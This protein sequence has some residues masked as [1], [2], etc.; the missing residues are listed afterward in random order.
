MRGRCCIPMS[1]KQLVHITFSGF[2]SWSESGIKTGIR[3]TVSDRFGSCPGLPRPEQSDLFSSAA[4][5]FAVRT[6]IATQLFIVVCFLRNSLLLAADFETDVKPVLLRRCTH[7]HGPDDVNGNVRL[8]TLSTDL[9]KDASA[10]ETWHDVLNVL[11][12]GEMPPEDAEPLT[13]S[14]R[15]A[16]TDWITA[17]LKRAVEVRRS[18]GGQV[19]IRR[20]N[21]TEYRNTMRDLLGLDLRY[22]PELLPDSPAE[23]GFTNNGSSL[24]MSSLQL[25]SYLSVAR[26]AMNRAIVTSAR[27]TVVDVTETSSA[28]DKVKDNWTSMLGR[29]GKFVLR[30]TEFPD[31]GEF[32]IQV[33]AR[34]ILPADA[35]Y[36]QL[37]VVLGYRADTQ[38]PSEEVGTVELKNTEFQ[39]YEFRGRLESF[40]L[41]SRTQSK[42]PGLLIWLTNAFSDGRPAPKPRQE[43][44]EIPGKEG[45]KPG[46]QKR[47]V[48]DVDPDFPKIEV[49]S[50]SFKAPVFE[51]W[52][53]SHHTR[54][55][56]P[57][58]LA[59]RDP[60]EYARVVLSRFMRRAFRR[61]VTDDEV[62][63]ML[64]YFHEV[65]PTFSTFEEA[66]RET[67]AM[68]LVAP[69]FLYLV[70]PSSGKSRG[71]T[72]HELASRLSYFLWSS[73]PDERLFELADSGQLLDPQTLSDEVDRLLADPRSWSFVSQ[74]SD[75]WLDLS[76]MNRIAVN[77]EYY[78]AFR[79]EL[80]PHMQRET[81]EFFNE[82][83]RNDHRALAFLDS[84]FVMLNRPL[85]EHYGLKGPRGIEFERVS[86]TE[87]NQRGGLLSQASILLTNSTG[88]DSHAVLRG[89]WIRKR[90]LDD[91]P[92]PPPPNVPNLDQQN[93]DVASLPL[94]EQL[95]EHH[96]NEACARCHR[97]ID[98]WGI[99]LEEFDAVGL[100]RDRIQRNSGK[101][102]L[103]FD[104]DAGATLPDGHEV[105][106]VAD[107]KAYLLSKKRDQFARTLVRRL[108]AYALGRSLELGDQ[109]TVEELAATFIES[110]YRLQSLVHLIVMSREFRSK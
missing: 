14:E 7:C 34:A 93:R 96:E 87:S 38:T 81:Q 70:E 102:R 10:A 109:D 65:R 37:R 101:N 82:I 2:N 4:G 5:G 33:R 16:L 94:K 48:W 57:D 83:L 90:L 3:K 44:V 21:R 66:M 36:P 54:I 46:K 78:P 27:P 6:A 106:G 74:F 84:D 43:I 52:P 26:N 108:M 79:N 23:G 60:T 8:D 39:E 62:D 40:P 35:P 47:L 11:N 77:P 41:Q 99:A 98:P 12:L 30:S 53:P 75:Q 17:E 104:V 59:E 103:T 13:D 67:L 45:K 32:V 61:P 9:V 88:E 29:T 1:G 92:A 86:L 71:L 58:D 51:N 76:G 28:A 56:F 63:L 31:E 110:D 80:K 19:V 95:R 105:N 91:P 100:V 64:A 69:E 55:L 50:V 20:L 73:M 22:G 97:G 89:V 24:Q 68:V 49:A 42:Y 25:E 107:L 72:S 18:T 15:A 85:A